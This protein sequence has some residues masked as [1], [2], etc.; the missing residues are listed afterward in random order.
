M[1]R[2]LFQTPF[3][4][5]RRSNHHNMGSDL[6]R[7]IVRKAK[8]AVALG[9]LPRPL[10][11]EASSSSSEEPSRPTRKR[12]LPWWQE[13]R[14][15]FGTLGNT[16][17]PVPTL[18]RDVD[19][20]LPQLEDLPHARLGSFRFA[21]RLGTF[22]TNGE[23]RLVGTYPPPDGSVVTIHFR[24]ELETPNGRVLCPMR[25]NKAGNHIFV[26]RNPRGRCDSLVRSSLLA[27]Y[28]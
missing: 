10:Q 13:G 15:R 7:D 6:A 9:V 1:S 11:A 17:Q 20:M 2:P 21:D 16:A 8:V 28:V 27:L 5:T 24:A 4:K 14:M 26:R 3:V 19:A 23:I 12:K 22:L 18:L 25:P